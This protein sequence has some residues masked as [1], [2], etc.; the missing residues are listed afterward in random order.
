RDFR[1]RSPLP[2]II[3]GIL[4]AALLVL[5]LMWIVSQVLN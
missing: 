1:N 2:Y 4:F 3:M 5:S